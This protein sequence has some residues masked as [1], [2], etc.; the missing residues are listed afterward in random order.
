MDIS[1]VYSG[2]ELGLPNRDMISEGIVGAGSLAVTAHGGAN[3]VDVAAG[4]AWVTGDTDVNHQPT[5]RVY[6]DATVNLGISP[7]PTNPRIVLVVAQ[8]NDATFVGVTRNWQLVAIHGTPAASPAAPALP[9]SALQL[10]SI[11]VPAAAASSAAYT[12]TDTRIGFG[13]GNIQTVYDRTLGSATTFDT[14]AII[15]ATG[16]DIEIT[17]QCRG[18]TAATSIGVLLRFNGDTGANYG[19]QLLTGTTSTASATEHSSATGATI[20]AV[21]AASATANHAGGGLLL[22]P[23]YANTTFFK[24]V[25]GT[26][27]WSQAITTGTMNVRNSLGAWASTAAIN[28]V[29]FFP[30]AGN[31]IAG[32]RMI[33]RVRR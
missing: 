20:G 26:T 2:D 15:P 8:I 22:I 23:N 16:T 25:H 12:I 33:V 10:A 4:A 27:G 1:G 24:N 6:N 9:A 32:S 28:R 21:A 31:F 30:G 11:T 18:D 17:Y 13:V 7:D 19:D 29:Q 14:G 3:S 5:Y